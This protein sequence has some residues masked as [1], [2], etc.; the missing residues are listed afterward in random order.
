MTRLR[1]LFRR[2]A[3]RHY[4]MICPG[5]PLP[6]G[7]GHL[8]RVTLTAR[9]VIVEGWT[10][11]PRVVLKGPVG[12]A[13]AIPS[14][15]RADVNDATGLSGD[16][17]FRL[18]VARGPGPVAVLLPDSGAVLPLPPAPR[19][20]RLR[21]RVRLVLRFLRDAAPALRHVPGALSGPRVVQA[22]AR[23]KTCLRLDTTPE[24]AAMETRLFDRAGLPPGPDPVPV[25]IVLPVYDAYDL[26]R[27]AL[28]RIEA[29][30]DLPW[31]LILIE[32]ASPDTRI[33]PFLRVWASER[34]QQVS[35]LENDRNL[36]FIGSVNRGL[37][38]AAARGHHVVLLNSD[39][40]VPPDWASRL[41]RPILVH[42]RVASVTPMSNDATILSVPHICTPAGLPRGTAEH[43]DTVARRFNPEAC[44]SVL[45]TGVGFCMAMNID[46][47]RRVQQ[48][49]PVFGRGYGEEVDWCQRVRALGGRHLGLPGL[50]VEHRGAGSFGSEAKRALIRRNNR[51]VAQRYPD[52]DADVQRFIAADPL[53]TPRLA[54]GLA[55]LGV[56]ATA[57]VP[58]YIAHSL[59]GGAET[60][61]GGRIAAD[62]DVGPGAVVLRVG[63]RRR[64]RIELHTPVGMTSGETDDFDFLSGLLEPIARRHV[65]YSCAV[66]DR[67]PVEIPQRILSLRRPGDRLE[68]LFH[69]WFPLSP[70]YTLLDSDGVY[71]GH[72]TT[73]RTDRAHST[74]RPDGAAVDLAGWRSA[75]GP[76][77]GAADDL[78]VFAEDGRTHV[79]R[80]YPD[81]AGRLRLVPHVLPNRP[82]R[83]AVPA[84]SPVVFG[85]LGNINLQKGARVVQTLARQASP[86]IV[87]IGNMDPAFPLPASVVV[88]G[89]YAPEDI[90][91]LARENGV[92][93]WLIPS[94]W[95]ETFSYTTHEALATGLPVLAFH[96]GA[97]GAAVAAAGN[98]IPVH[99][100]PSP[101]A[102][103]A[104]FV[105]DALASKPG[106]RAA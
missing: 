103:L 100:D 55:A 53:V 97:Q 2:Y 8:D 25:T 67:D 46:Y 84:G 62:L 66:G 92:T 69:D 64:W 18:E 35:L 65:I 82:E 93:H 101:Q 51:I 6:G 1:A 28:A 50:F 81:A 45:P 41:L 21:A 83:I 49:D 7:A 17:G 94:V 20:L 34:S 40:F 30:T 23:I 14:L 43:I 39:A 73:E 36:G 91:R 87:V 74:L 68:V 16:L 89:S 96:I 32:D 98:G 29:H 76:L 52:Y 19:S 42:D 75:W 5:R 48:L 88:T 47:L 79:A 63:G 104:A 12:Q 70:S 10:T 54:L 95:P 13:A 61:L 78:T 27:E 71:R 106:L 60:W 102:D 56:A 4:R 22:R 72:V 85:V 57:S 9:S 90:P 105:L 33:L 37:E 77:I 80:V 86:R 58:V 44:V 38:A 99:F 59:G 26:L 3:E 11:A 15:D 31:H 24:P